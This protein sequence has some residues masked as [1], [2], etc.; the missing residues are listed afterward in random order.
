MG[1]KSRWRKLRWNLTNIKR[2][3]FRKDGKTRRKKTSGGYILIDKSGK[4]YYGGSSGKVPSR[5]YDK[6]FGR[7]DERTVKNKNTVKDAFWF[8]VKFMSLGKAREW[9][10]RTRLKK[11]RR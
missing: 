7:S 8:M 10:R 11:D 9:D 6:Y 2:L 4:R 1:K 3:R 5:L